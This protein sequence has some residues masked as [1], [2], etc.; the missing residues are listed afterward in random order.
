[1]QVA[2]S[3][4]NELES[5]VLE[6]ML[7]QASA[8]Q[9][10]LAEQ[11]KGASVLRR[12][13]TGAGFSTRLQTNEKTKAMEAKFIGNTFANIK[14]LNHPMTFILFVKNGMIDTLEGAATDE[15]TNDVDFS[16]VQFEM[17]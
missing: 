6:K 11:L 10:T 17:I 13:N 14:G 15:S 9:F 8:D 12:Q 2:K 1:M 4:L 5:A 7:R 3:R 16:N